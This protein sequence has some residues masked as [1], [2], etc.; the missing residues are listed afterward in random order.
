M[1]VTAGVNLA[2]QNDKYAGAKDF[3]L[4]PHLKVQYELSPSMEVYG[5]VTGDIDKVNLHTLSAE[6]LWLDASIPITN[7]N[8][9]L[10]FR[11][12]LT[13]KL[14]R[15]VSVGA[16]VSVASMKNYYFYQTV[17]DN[18]NPSGFPVG[19]V[20]D[21]FTTV[22]DR[23]TQRINPF[24]ELTYEHGESFR[25]L[26]RGD[27]Y[28][29]DTD[30]LL[31]AWHRPTYRIN[32]SAR[33]NLYEKISL[34]ASFV[35]Q[36]GMKTLDPVT[37]TILSLDPAMDLNFKARYFFSK[38][39]SAFAQFNNVLSNNYPLYQSYSVRGFQVLAGVSW[40]F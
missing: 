6:N 33:Y 1:V 12:G 13:G 25:V 34:E 3:H 38:Q 36:G 31:G 15:N 29:Y 35:A 30:V 22:Y 17:R 32:T 5:V 20:F 39:F 24:A 19:V 11:G 28:S 26:L 37:A 27:Y 21:K 18:L 14:G 4:Y 23:N 40:S 8:R 9:A 2:I 7:T 16:G 10:E